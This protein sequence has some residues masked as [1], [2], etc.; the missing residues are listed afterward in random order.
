M[1]IPEL[2]PFGDTFFEARLR[3]I[4]AA[5]FLNSPSSGYV[6]SVSTPADHFRFPCVLRCDA[7]RAV[8]L[9]LRF[10]LCFVLPVLV[11]DVPFLD[12][13]FAPVPFVPLLLVL[14]AVGIAPSSSLRCESE[15]LHRLA[16]VA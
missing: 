1:R 5:S 14:A 12:A 16:R 8:V 15:A 6:D 4:V 3:A 9:L 2:G 7:P 13:L 11:V 10:V